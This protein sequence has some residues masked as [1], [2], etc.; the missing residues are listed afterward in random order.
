[1]ACGEGLALA[2]GACVPD[3]FASDLC[4]S[5]AKPRA[6]GGC[7][8]TACPA[9]QALDLDHGLCLPES[10][11]LL[12][13]LHGRPQE[14]D[15][16]RRATC[17]EGVLTSHGNRLACTSGRLSCARGERFAEASLDAGADATA[18]AGV[19]VGTCEALAPCGVGEMLDEIGGTCTRVVRSG[20]VDAGTWARLAIG[21]DGGEGTNAFCAPVRAAM[22]GG[23]TATG[24]LP[25]RFQ[26]R[27]VLPDNDVTQAN[28]RLSAHPGTATAA[29]DAGERSLE[30]L[31]Q[32]LHFYGGSSLAASVSLDVTCSPTGS[33]EPT[34]EVPADHR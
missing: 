26:V 15:D 14:P 33:P 28:A 27:L 12:T 11:V 29:A 34:L 30:Q 3:R 16:T 18:D 24:A 2:F 21:T 19:H 32:I 1:M 25:A 13:L 8:R 22:T 20:A 23:S 9:G 17:H 31:V 7:V 4:G 10:T 6:G 5:A